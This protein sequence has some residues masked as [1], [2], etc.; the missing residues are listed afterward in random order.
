VAIFSAAGC[1]PTN[2]FPPLTGEFAY[3]ANA[4][5]GTIS[6]FSINSSTGA[7]T[8]VQ[9]VAAAPGFRVF[10]LVLHW[11]NEFLYTTIDDENEVESFEYR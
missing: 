7:L 9:S 8:L 2:D 6:V 10:G 5:D 1:G 11:S 3:V 4:G